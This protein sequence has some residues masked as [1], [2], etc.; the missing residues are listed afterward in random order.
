[1][2]EVKGF[3]CVSGFDGFDVR[4]IDDIEYTVEISCYFLTKWHED[5]LV[6]HEDILREKFEEESEVGGEGEEQWYPID[7][8]FVSKVCIG[9]CRTSF[10]PSRMHESQGENLK[11]FLPLLRRCRGYNLSPYVHTTWEE[12]SGQWL[13]FRS[14]QAA[15]GTLQ[16]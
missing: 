7:L 5:R 6:L 3:A 12:T 10:I 11:V 13:S 2:P 1:M 16:I 9:M 15:K 14:D 8:E 4:K